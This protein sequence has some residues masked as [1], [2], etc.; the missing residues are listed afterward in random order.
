MY[1]SLESNE[2]TE[3]AIEGVLQ[4]YIFLKVQVKFFYRVS[5]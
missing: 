3:A 2:S 4:K 1:L 5:S